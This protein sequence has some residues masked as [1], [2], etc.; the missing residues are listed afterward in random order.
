MASMEVW[1]ESKEK[2]TC[3]FVEECDLIDRT[4]HRG[5]AE[6][7]VERTYQ[8]LPRNL[9]KGIQECFNCLTLLLDKIESQ[10]KISRADEQLI[11]EIERRM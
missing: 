7:Q 8:G 4:K 3:H 5:R 10:E 2:I 9:P 11:R 6:I 1:F